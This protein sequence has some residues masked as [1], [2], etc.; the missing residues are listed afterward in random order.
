MFLFF[1]NRMG[2]GKSLMISA[3][4]TLVLLFLLGVLR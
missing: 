2:C 3:A 4:I 1:N